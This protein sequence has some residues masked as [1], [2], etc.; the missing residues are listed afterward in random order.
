MHK[1]FYQYFLL[2]KNVS[3]IYFNPNCVC[4]IMSTIAFSR[5][6]HKLIPQILMSAHMQALYQ[7][8]CH[9]EDLAVGRD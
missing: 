7:Y 3:K 2:D 9:P 4:D 5:N 8:F 6:I 1:L